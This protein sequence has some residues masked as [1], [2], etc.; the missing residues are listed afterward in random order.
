MK[1]CLSF[2]ISIIFL[3]I[4]HCKTVCA[5]IATSPVSLSAHCGDSSTKTKS[6]HK[7]QP[8]SNPSGS[9]DCACAELTKLS[10]HGVSSE[11]FTQKLYAV[12]GLYL[13]IFDSSS[14]HLQHE[15]KKFTYANHSPPQRTLLEISS[16]S[17]SLRAPPL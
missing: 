3:L 16:T 10:I 14:L 4:T 7:Q 9:K 11:F 8:Q 2:F 6:C 12:P 1:Q 17:H 13:K 5:F 15:N